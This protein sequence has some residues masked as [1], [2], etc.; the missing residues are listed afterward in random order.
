MKT[1]TTTKNLFGRFSFVNDALV[2]CVVSFDYQ[3][4]TTIDRS[5]IIVLANTRINDESFDVHRWTRTNSCVQPH[6]LAHRLLSSYIF[7]LFF[8]F[9]LHQ[10]LYASTLIPRSRLA[11][12][13]RLQHANTSTAEHSRFRH[14]LP[15]RRISD[16]F[17]L[18][19][20]NRMKK[21][22]YYSQK[23]VVRNHFVYCASFPLSM[24]NF[25][26]ETMWAR[27]RNE[28]YT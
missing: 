12:M 8:F 14:F 5:L 25:Y 15:V 11:L 13:P 7:N 2:N 23:I 27:D 6:T 9:S 3:V 28:P 20:K 1:E 19:P 4:P 26:E 21:S 16:S 24:R 18:H 17:T 10:T 22:K